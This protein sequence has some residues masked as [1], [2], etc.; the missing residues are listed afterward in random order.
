V[1]D[2]CAV[3]FRQDGR[4]CRRNRMGFLW[5][6]AAGNFVNSVNSVQTQHV[7]PVTPH[8]VLISAVQLRMAFGAF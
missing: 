1:V 8:P 5:V 7:S 4:M 6:Y 2:S 3:I